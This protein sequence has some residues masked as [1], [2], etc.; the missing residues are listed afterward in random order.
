MA[1]FLLD[2]GVF[3][4]RFERQKFGKSKSFS[5][6]KN[7]YKKGNVSEKEYKEKIHKIFSNDL[8][9]LEYKMELIDD[10]DEVIVCY[11]GIFGRR[12]RGKY[13]PDYKRHK[14]GIK[15]TKHKGIDIRELIG[16]CGYNP[17]KIKENWKGLYIIDKEGDDLIAE[18][19][20]IL[21]KQDKE[22][23]I[24]SEDRDFLQC[25]S[26][27]PKVR[28]YNL[29]FEI[30]ED[31]VEYKYGLTSK[32]YVDWK[33]LV[34]DKSDNIPGLPNVGEVK[35][36]QL[37]KQYGVVENLPSEITQYYRLSDIGIQEV[38]KQH[39]VENG[40]SMTACKKKYG[41]HWESLENG[42]SKTLIPTP[43]I[44]KFQETIPHVKQYFEMVDYA[45][46]LKIWKKIVKL[47]L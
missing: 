14:S 10:I 24:I 20:E 12:P 17:M 1:V 26:W 41:K 47:P 37:L 36:T 23:V 39:R 13:Y 32:M 8:H 22:V 28:I 30:D 21:I 44:M 16:D 38:L 25:L 5:W 18:N 29:K 33:C 3:V 2:G 42:T 31:W 7:N 43:I 15:A 35:A 45:L 40:L 46:K 27:S 9:H 6:W 11:D 34:G 19:L 4:G